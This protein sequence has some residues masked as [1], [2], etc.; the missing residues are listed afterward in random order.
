LYFTKSNS[1]K[2]TTQVVY[3][4]TWTSLSNNTD[5]TYGWNSSH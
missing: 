3:C 1:I 5:A 2:K 4:I